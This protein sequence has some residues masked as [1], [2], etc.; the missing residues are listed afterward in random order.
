MNQHLANLI[1]DYQSSVLEAVALMQA[2]GIPMPAS[3]NA[4]VATQI[5]QRGLLAGGIPYFK[6]GFGC[7]VDLPH[8]KV[9]FDFGS[10]GQIDGFDAWRL[11]GFAGTRLA[12]YGFADEAS[13]NSCFQSEVTA[14]SLTYSGYLLYYLARAA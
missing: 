12:A 3:S 5:P 13:L 4:W 7:A 9:D 10:E 11:A 14:G 8:G 6:H 2:S 1:S